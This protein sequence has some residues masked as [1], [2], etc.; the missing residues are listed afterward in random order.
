[1]L[2]HTLGL[3][4]AIM[5]VFAKL[6]SNLPFISLT[7][8]LPGKDSDLGRKVGGSAQSL[9]KGE[10]HFQGNIAAQSTGSQATTDIRQTPVKSTDTENKQVTGILPEGFFDNKE[11]DLRARGIKPV[12]PDVK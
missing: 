5:T 12:K 3:L 11:A 8:L 2:Q 9:E 6:N 1:V 10:D 7:F 4:V